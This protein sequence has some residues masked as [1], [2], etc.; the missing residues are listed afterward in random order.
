MN[1]KN[2]ISLDL[3]FTLVLNE[4]THINFPL[5]EKNNQYNFPNLKN[6]KI[7]FFYDCES[8]QMNSPKD[9]I[10]NL[11]N[12]FKFCPLL[13]NLVMYYELFEKN[14][15]ELNLILNGIKCLKYLRSLYIYTKT[16]E[17]SIIK[18]NEFY[19]I[20]PELINYCPFLN[21]INMEIS[22]FLKYDF[23]Y[24]KNINYKIND[25]VIDKY[26][27]IKTL[28][29]KSS[30]LTYLC[31]NKENKKVVIRKFKKSRI[32]NV[33]YLFE[34]EKY[35]LQ[36]YKNSPNIINYIE[37]ISDEHFEYIVY[38]YLEDILKKIKSKNISIKV[39]NILE[40]FYSSAKKDK[41]IILLPILPSNI[42]IKNNFDVVLTGFGYINIYCDD[43]DKKDKL[44]NFYAKMKEYH[45]EIFSLIPMSDSY[46]EYIND[47]KKYYY[48]NNN[49][50]YLLAKI[51]YKKIKIKNKIKFEKKLNIGKII[52]NKDN[53][54]TLQENSIIIYDRKKFDKITEIKINEEYSK[55]KE[56]DENKEKNIKINSYDFILIDDN[57]LI[58]LYNNN[59]YTVSF[60]NNNLKKE[61]A[62]FFGILY[63]IDNTKNKDTS[64]NL[65][66]IV[67]FEKKDII[68]I[69]SK[70]AVFAFQLNKIE[71]KLTIIKFYNNLNSNYIFKLENNY[72]IPLIS[73]GNEKII[74]YKINDKNELI[75]SF[76]YIHNINNYSFYENK[77]FIQDN[78][79]CYILILNFI[80]IIR[81]NYEQKKIDCLFRCCLGINEIKNIFPSLKGI[82][83]IESGDYFRK[84]LTKINGEYEIIKNNYFLDNYRIYDIAKDETTEGLYIIGSETIIEI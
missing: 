18:T 34:N 13:E 14:P 49:W 75:P 4:N 44:Y 80:M 64:I 30:Y 82:F 7:D 45:E 59:L 27:Y 38:E 24:E 41:N 77:K 6:L 19:D 17:K 63:G 35:C 65:R 32:D 3:T 25:I 12:N 55:D 69:T 28:G 9:L 22:E 81:I 40:K 29:Q 72:D 67:Y 68:F 42:L 53:I 74:F 51:K 54:F 2:L 73:V 56:K 20:Y 66:D 39:C 79:Y 5:T 11:S 71:K 36:K 78:D 1:F 46:N 33:S 62:L 10:Q 21:D 31:K 8:C 70:N 84:Y 61:D 15:N 58:V 57:I 43:I 48:L 16:E 50:S 60:N 52:I 37:F 26:L 76:D 83:F 47:I 23:L